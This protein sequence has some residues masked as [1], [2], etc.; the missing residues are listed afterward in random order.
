MLIYSFRQYDC[1]YTGTQEVP[2][3]TTAIPPYT[4]FNVPPQQEGFYPFMDV[5]T[6]WVLKPGGLPPEPAP[7]PPNYSAQNKQ[8]AEAILSATDWA[9]IPSVADP[10]QS[11]PYLMNQSEFIAYRSN[12]RAVAVEPPVDVLIDFSNAPTEQWSPI[13]VDQAALNAALAEN[14]QNTTIGV[15]TI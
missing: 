14:T 13:T 15:S 8:N 6:G 3:G 9:S 12:V 4:T 5:L 2:D 10:A 7:P 1:A 11:D